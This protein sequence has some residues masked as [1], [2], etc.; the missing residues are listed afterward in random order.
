MATARLW[1]VA[2]SDKQTVRERRLEMTLG[3]PRG[4]DRSTNLRGMRAA[5]SQCG[6][7]RCELVLV[8]FFMRREWSG[9]EPFCVLVRDQGFGN[10]SL[11]PPGRA[12]DPRWVNRL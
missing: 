5:R 6:K 3:P 9:S 12:Y 11:S 7:R 10:G 1:K 4:A 2:L 8:E